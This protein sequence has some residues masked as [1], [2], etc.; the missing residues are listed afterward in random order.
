MKVTY[1]ARALNDLDSIY[2]YICQHNPQAAAVVTSVIQ[3]Q[4]SHLADH[5]LMAPI[6][7]I[8]SVRNL[9]IARYP[10]K[11]YYRIRGDDVIVLHIR[12]SRRAPWSGE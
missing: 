2:G 6:T 9:T 5:P 3:H 4:I 10:Y 1:S 8:P 12:H 7:T 11:A